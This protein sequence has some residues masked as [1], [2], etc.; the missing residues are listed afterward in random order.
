MRKIVLPFLIIAALL[1]AQAGISRTG[2]TSIWVEW[3]LE[4]MPDSFP[5]KAICTPPVSGWLTLSRMQATDTKRDVVIDAA[6]GASVVRFH[7]ADDNGD[8]LEWPAGETGENANRYIDFAVTPPAAREMRVTKI[9]MLIGAYS[10]EAMKCRINAGIGDAFA[11]AQ[12]IFDASQNAL[13]DKTMIPLDL[14]PTLTIPAGETLHL[15]VLP[16]HENS[17]G[18]GK[19]IL[20]R[21]VIVQ[22]QMAEAPQNED[23]RATD[24]FSAPVKESRNGVVYIFRDGKIYTLQGQQVP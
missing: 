8:M 1:L 5:S 14:T 23:I 21:S 3:P 2:E 6:T 10:T 4:F 15:R 9:T 11:D 16:W 18:I 19:Y 17:S 22:G 20:L 7:N 12:T 24:A 13:P